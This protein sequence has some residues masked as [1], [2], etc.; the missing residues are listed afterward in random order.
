MGLEG[1]PEKLKLAIE[2]QDKLHA[3]SKSHIKFHHHFVTPNSAI[4]IKSLTTTETSVLTGLHA[5]ADLSITVQ[6]IFLELDFVKGLVIM[7][8]CYHRLKLLDN[9]NKS[10]D[11]FENFPVSKALK[12][13]Y[14]KVNGE[15]FL[16][17]YFLRLACQQTAAS[18]Y[19]MDEVKHKTHAEQCL[20]RAILEAAA[21]EGMWPPFLYAQSTNASSR[22]NN[23]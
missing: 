10:E 20:F 17:R 12:E 23:Y 8:C 9:S 16:R 18:F 5:C 11:W 19:E 7:P 4:A 2:R 21:R 22:V 14:S 3:E 1:N 15:R 13:V 6:R